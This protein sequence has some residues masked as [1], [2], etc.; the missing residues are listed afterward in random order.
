[1]LHHFRRSFMTDNLPVLSQKRKLCSHMK[2]KRYS[3]PII[4]LQEDVTIDRVLLKMQLKHI[5]TVVITSEGQPRGIVTETDIVKFLEDDKTERSLDK[6]P[7]TELMKKRLI[8]ITR[9]QQDHL[10]QCASRIEIFKIG[11]VIVLDDDGYAIGITTKTDITNAYSESYQGKYKVKDFMSKMV[12]TCRKSD[13]LKF[14]LNSINKNNISRLI[15]TDNDGNP[16]GVVTRDTFVRH[17]SKF[18]KLYSKSSDFWKPTKND[19]L[20]PIETLMHPDLL[21][22][23]LEDDL[24]NAAHIMIN[25]IVSGL[26]VVDKSRNLV[27]LISKSDVVRAFS[28]VESNT[29]LLEKY[30]QTH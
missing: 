27:G 23:N 9:G 25:K 16:V 30:K 28:Q 26:P 2:A 12:I 20:L 7:V 1:M 8:T 4:T 22:V 11:A 24:A 17:T 29:I 21:T 13:S 15:V 5:K 3:S 6:I 19:S 14:V 10:H 18:K